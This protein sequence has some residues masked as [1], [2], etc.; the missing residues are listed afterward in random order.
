AALDEEITVVTRAVSG[1]P[2]RQIRNAFTREWE[3]RQA[4]IEPFP[5]RPAG[6]VVAS[7]VEKA[8]A[9]FRRLGARGEA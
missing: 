2:N 8:E 9:I 7:I 4:E 3:G 1:K 6:R 5:V